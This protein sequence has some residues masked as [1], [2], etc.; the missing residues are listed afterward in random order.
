MKT[1]LCLLIAVLSVTACS[2][3]I[4]PSYGPGEPVDYPVFYNQLA[5]YGTWMDYAPYGSVWRPTVAVGFSP[6]L[7]NGY[8]FYSTYGWTWYSY[9]SWGWAPFHYGRWH[10]DVAFGWLWIP[11]TVWGPGWVAWRTGGGY[12]GW[13]PLGPNISVNVIVTGGHTIVHDH[14]IFVREK[15]FN[16]HHIEHHRVDRS[17]N[18]S[19]IERSNIVKTTRGEKT[20]IY[21][22]GPDREEWQRSSGKTV[23][24]VEI[25][26]S[27]RPRQSEITNK[28]QLQM[29]RPYYDK[30]VVPRRESNPTKQL[31]WS[32]DRNRNTIRN[33]QPTTIPKR[34]TN[35]SPRISPRPSQPGQKPV[36][37]SKPPAKPRKRGN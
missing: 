34:N 25:R 17:M 13:A 6:Y 1:K 26:K 8:W 27:N 9:Y 14:W 33:Q 24:P 23:T 20:S 3:N 18:G 35:Q 32:H 12:C 36:I 30:G 22:P 5:P 37:K 10:F 16:D 7:T 15:D 21:Q 19:L 11:D 2:E 28:N 29:Y 31:K 4:S